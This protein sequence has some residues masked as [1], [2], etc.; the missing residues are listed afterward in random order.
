MSEAAAKKPRGGSRKPIQSVD[1]ALTLLE[2]LAAENGETSLQTLSRK[3]GLN[4]STAHRLLRALQSHDLVQQNATTRHY[5]LG[6]KLL[7]LAWA[8]RSQLDLR[9]RARPSLEHLARQS[10]ET[11]NL[12]IR[13]GSAAVYLDQAASSQ[14]IRAFT[15][16]G[17]RVPLYCT[18]V[19]KVLL[20]YMA[21]DEV[22]AFL[23]QKLVGYT[24][25]TITD[26]AQ[27]QDEITRTRGQGWALD[28]EE[29]E[30]D[31]RCI[32]APVFDDQ[33]RVVAALSIAGPAQR[34][35]VGRIEDL[36]P[37]VKRAAQDVSIALGWPA[38]HADVIR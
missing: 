32:A 17:A 22:L 27:L 2:T 18:G 37:I 23:A 33:G 4:T 30:Q 26:P 31:V 29:M 11:A 25:Q 15:Q 3:A 20:A 7:E 13:E 34:M 9:Q 35:G 8:V 36:V 28:G 10:G 14:P 12:A 24:P 5:R 1:R 19:G 38:S 16:V 6:L 21:P